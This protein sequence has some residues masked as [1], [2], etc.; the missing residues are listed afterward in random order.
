MFNHLTESYCFNEYTCVMSYLPYSLFNFI[1]IWNMFTY[2]TQTYEHIHQTWQNISSDTSSCSSSTGDLLLSMPLLIT[3]HSA[4][5]QA[6]QVFLM[7]PWHVLENH[8]FSGVTR[9]KHDQ[10]RGNSWVPMNCGKSW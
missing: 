10:T 9:I 2:N 4:L 6:S 5:A 7:E 8:C 1:H 3:S